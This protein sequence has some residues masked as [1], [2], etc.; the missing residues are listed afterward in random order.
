MACFKHIMGSLTSESELRR[1]TIC[2]RIEQGL[3][4]VEY[5]RPFLMLMVT[6]GFVIH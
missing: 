5:P 6:L 2:I 1:E 4:H 3:Y